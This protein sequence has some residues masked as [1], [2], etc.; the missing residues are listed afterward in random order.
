MEKSKYAVAFAAVL[1]LGVFIIPSQA[2][3]VVASSIDTPTENQVLTSNV[4]T[5]SGIAN[6]DGSRHIETITYNIDS[7]AYTGSANFTPAGNNVNVPWS[8]DTPALSEGQHT[9]VMNVTQV[10]NAGTIRTFVL[11]TRHFE[12]DAITPTSNDLSYTTDFRTPVNI[13]LEVVNGATFQIVSG[14]THGTLSNLDAQAGTLTY[15]PDDSASN[16]DD[17]FTFLTTDGVT[18]S[19][20][21]TVGIHVN[22]AAHGHNWSVAEHFADATK[23]IDFTK[24]PE[25]TSGLRLYDAISGPLGMNFMDLLMSFDLKGIHTSDLTDGQIVWLLEHFDE[26]SQ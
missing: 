4:V 26:L 5:V 17:S 6:P 23:D 7:G 9:V 10:N 13:Q 24:V 19:T 14:P 3:A 18:N 1:A 11:V 21:S 22:A 16:V 8:F 15:T 2:F 25:S 20:V 12:V